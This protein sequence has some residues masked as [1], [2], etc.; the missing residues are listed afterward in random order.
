MTSTM[1]FT[2]FIPSINGFSYGI[3]LPVHRRKH[4]WMWMEH[5]S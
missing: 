5:P 4:G 2:Y 3:T 1:W